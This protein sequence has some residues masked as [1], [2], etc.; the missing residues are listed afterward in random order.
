[1]EPQFYITELNNVVIDLENFLQFFTEVYKDLDNM[2]SYL[3]DILDQRNE[4][5]SEMESEYYSNL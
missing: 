2:S 4:L 5:K 3:L 1:M